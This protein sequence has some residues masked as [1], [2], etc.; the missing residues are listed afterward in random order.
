[1]PTHVRHLKSGPNKSSKVIM[2]HTT[3]KPAKPKKKK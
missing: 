2:V 3:K 1:M